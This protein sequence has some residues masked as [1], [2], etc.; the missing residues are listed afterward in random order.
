VRFI[1]ATIWIAFIEGI[2]Q[3]DYRATEFPGVG[4]QMVLV[5]AAV[6]ATVIDFAVQVVL[7]ILAQAIQSPNGIAQITVVIATILAIIVVIA[8]SVTPIVIVAPIVVVAIPVSPVIRITIA[9]PGIV[10]TLRGCHDGQT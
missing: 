3:I 5:P 2:L 4:I 9:T 8:I 1:R 7:K 6:L 10:G